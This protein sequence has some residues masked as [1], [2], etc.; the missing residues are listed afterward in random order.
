VHASLDRGSDEGARSLRKDCNFGIVGVCF[1]FP[2][3]PYPLKH[4]SNPVNLIS[5]AE[6]LASEEGT[7]CH[8]SYSNLD[9]RPSHFAYDAVTSTFVQYLARRYRQN[10]TTFLGDTSAK[11]HTNNKIPPACLLLRIDVRPIVH[12]RLS[13][14]L[15]LH[16]MVQCRIRRSDDLG[17]ASAIVLYVR[18]TIRSAL[19]TSANLGAPCS[20]LSSP[21]TI[22]TRVRTIGK[23]AAVPHGSWSVGET[24][25]CSPTIRYTIYTVP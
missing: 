2:L 19:G 24:G 11:S 14:V 10:D 21:V 15:A 7:D 23:L 5:L 22:S 1:V 8:V 6:T 25:G 4:R 12:Y 13:I 17:A 9:L 20:L 3:V 18:R 16:R